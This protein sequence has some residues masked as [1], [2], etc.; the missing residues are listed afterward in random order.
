MPSCFVASDCASR[1]LKTI[2]VVVTASFLISGQTASAEEAGL[3]QLTEEQDE[4]G[5]VSVG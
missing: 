5:P 2:L 1:F 3:N 4:E